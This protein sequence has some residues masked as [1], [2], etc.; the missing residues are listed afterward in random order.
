MKITSIETIHLAKGITVHAG[1]VHWLWVRIHTD[2]GLV[3]LGETVLQYKSSSQVWV[4][5]AGSIG[6]AAF[7]CAATGLLGRLGVRVQL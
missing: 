5:I 6:M 3:G 4:I 2:S 7:V 1:P